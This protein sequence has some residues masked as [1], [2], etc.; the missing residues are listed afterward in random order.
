MNY[1]SIGDMAQS[2]QLRRHGVELQRRLTALT[3]ELNTGVQADPAKAVSGDFKA[4]AGIE[5]SLGLLDSYRT[6]TGEAALFASGIQTTLGRLQDLAM[7]VAPTLL[8]AGTTGGSQY[9]DAAANDAAQRFA[10]AVSS[11]NA[12]VADRY[13]LS[14]TATDRPPISGAEDI[15]AALRTAIAGQVTASGVASA[16]QAW[17]DAPAGGGGF[18]DAAYGGSG[19]ATDIPI[20]EADRVKLDVTALDPAVRDT[21]RGLALGALVADG[22]LQGDPAARGLLSRTA[23]ETLAGS[24]P[25]LAALRGRVGTIEAHIAGTARDNEGR[26]AA[27]GLARAAILAADPYETASA[28]EAVQTQIE[29][30][31]TITARLS[32]LSLADYLR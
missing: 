11:L 5:H 10:S 7:G 16:V 20:G 19:A 3:E 4:L 23:G 25:D 2:F 31:Y 6:S 8:S 27:L 28:L 21:L 30:L 15:L 1:V 29:T 14:G 24:N 26:A 12:K 32:R 9:V 18:A 22:A 17:F 13:L